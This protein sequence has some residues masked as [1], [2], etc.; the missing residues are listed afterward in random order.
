MRAHEGLVQTTG[1]GPHWASN[2]LLGS[3][4][5]PGMEGLKGTCA[6]SS[7]RHGPQPS[8]FSL[9]AAE[10]HKSRKGLSLPA[11]EQDSLRVSPPRAIQMSLFSFSKALSYLY[12]W[13]KPEALCPCLLPPTSMRHQN[14]LTC[15][16]TMPL[17]LWIV[18]GWKHGA[19]ALSTVV[20][21]SASCK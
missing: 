2:S 19:L 10:Q 6:G 21:V 7:V 3:R 16:S 13:K 20:S 1:R 9:S 12:A 5:A 8:S 11:E 15:E 18:S 14:V 4:P 17:P